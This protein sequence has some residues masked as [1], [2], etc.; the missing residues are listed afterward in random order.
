MSDPHENDPGED[1]ERHIGQEE[2]DPWSV[3]PEPDIVWRRES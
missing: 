1:P 3:E 2:P